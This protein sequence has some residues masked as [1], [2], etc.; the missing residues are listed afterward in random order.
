MDGSGVCR[1]N[2]SVSPPSICDLTP[3]AFTC[4]LTTAG[5]RHQ[6]L[7]LLSASTDH[8]MLLWQFDPTHHLYTASARVGEAGAASGSGGGRG[9]GFYGCLWVG[10][11]AVAAGGAVGA[12]G[13][14]CMRMI[15]HTYTGGGPAWV[16][17]SGGDGAG[18]WQP[19]PVPSGRW[20]VLGWLYCERL[21]C[22]GLWCAV[23]W[24]RS[25]GCSDGCHLGLE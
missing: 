12:A 23:L 18:V 20:H 1:T 19:V 25:C 3:C 7:R 11:R 24:S 17:G 21:N 9:L 6:P 16:G 2:S 13:G 5:T 8:C 14:N 22:V 15:A 4:D 10:P